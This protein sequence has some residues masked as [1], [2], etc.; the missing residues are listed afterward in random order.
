MN[1]DE[2]NNKANLLAQSSYTRVGHWH[3][4]WQKLGR[5]RRGD[6]MGTQGG[7]GALMAAGGLGTLWGLTG[8]GCPR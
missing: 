8:S 3:W 7:S 6:V 1:E 4:A 5:Q 2:P